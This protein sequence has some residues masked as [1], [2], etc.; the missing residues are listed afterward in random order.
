MLGLI[1][2]RLVFAYFWVLIGRMIISFIPIIRQDWRPPPWLMPVIDVIYALT[3]PPLSLL[4]RVIPQP[5]G[6]P[7]DLSFLVLVIFLQAVLIP[8][9]C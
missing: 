2:C 4:R 3:E 1:L 5:M 7:I 6:L 9:L 8:V